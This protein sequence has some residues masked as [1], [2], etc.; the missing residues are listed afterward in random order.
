MSFTTLASLLA[1]AL[2]QGMQ[3]NA[4]LLG[5][6]DGGDPGNAFEQRQQQALRPGEHPEMPSPRTK[7]QFEVIL[8]F[9]HETGK[10]RSIPELMDPVYMFSGEFYENVVDMKIRGRGLDFVWGRKYGSKTIGTTPMGNGWD[11]SYNIYLTPQ[12]PDFLVNNGWGRQDLYQYDATTG[13]W[14]RPQVF[15][16]LVLN[17]DGTFTLRFQDTSSW[18][19]MG[20]TGTAADGKLSMTADRNANSM[21]FAYDAQGRLG[22]VTDTLKRKI[23]IQYNSSG[24]VSTVT[25]FDGRSLKYTYHTG[26]PGGGNP[27][28]L[29]SATSP[30]VTGTPTGNDFPSGKTVRYTYSMGNPQAAL[31]GNLLTVTDARGQTYLQNEYYATTNPGALEFDR[32]RRQH[33]GN[34]TDV[35]DVVYE[36]LLAAP[37]NNNATIKAIVN[38]RMGHVKEL[39]YDA[40]HDPVMFQE[41]TGVSNP[42]LPTS[43]TANR[44]GP[45]LRPSDPALFTTIWMYNADSLVTRVVFPNKNEERFVYDSSN[46]DPRARGNLLEHQHL[47]GAL[48]GDQSLIVEKFTYVNGFGGGCCGAN[49]VA[50]EMDGRGNLTRHI[51][52]TRGNRV[53]TDYAEPGTVEEWEY[54]SN[55]QM[56]ARMH[57]DNGS[58]SRRRDEYSYH[59]S[60]PETGYPASQT[61]DVNNLALKTQFRTDG[62]GNVVS[63]LDPRGNTE[64][65]V[66][67]QLD[68]EIQRFERPVQTPS[69]AVS[70]ETQ[71]LFD[72]N[73]NRVLELRLNVDGDGAVDPNAYLGTSIDYDIL[74]QP[75]RIT[76]EVDATHNAVTEMTYNSNWKKSK[77]SF[78]QAVSGA[79]PFNAVDF[80][81]DERDLLY[82]SVLAKGGPDQS[83]VQYD[84]DGN[85]NLALR[86]EGLEGTTHSKA[87]SHDGF[88]R[89]VSETDAMGNRKV[90][91]HD[92]NG[93]T[94]SVR[95][96]GEQQDIAGSANNIRLRER[97]LYYDRLN[98]NVREEEELFDPLTQAPILVGATPD[99]VVV[100]EWTLAPA[101]MPLVR[102]NDNQ[103][104]TTYKYDTVNRISSVTD[105]VG[106]EVRKF[107]DLNSNLVNEETTELSSVM[108]NPD[109]FFSDHYEYDALNRQT[110]RIDNVGNRSETRYDSRGNQ[111]VMTDPVGNVTRRAYDG[112]NRM[113]QTELIMTSDGTGAGAPAGSI[114]NTTTWDDSSRVIGKADD[115]GNSTAFSYDSLNR[116]TGE[117]LADGTQAAFSYDV[118]DN[119]VSRLDANGTS[120]V[121]SYDLLNRRVQLNVSVGAGVS[122]DTTFVTYQYDGRS[123][124]M[125]C[126]DDDSLVERS[127]DSMDNLL[128]ETLNGQTTGHVFDGLNNNLLLNYPSGR[129]VASTYDLLERKTK[130]TDGTGLVAQM[131][132]LGFG[133]LGRIDFG[134][135]T[136]ANFTFDGHS[137]S[138]SGVKR[139]VAV[140]HRLLSNGAIFHSQ[141]FKWDGAGNKLER[142]DSRIG[143]FGITHSY[144]Y[145]SAYRLTRGAS[146]DSSGVLR[147]ETYDLDGRGNRGTTSGGST[148]GTY[149][150]DGTVPSPADLQ[151]NQYT[152]TAFDER[153][154]DLNGN[155]LRTS[156]SGCLA[157]WNGDYIIDASDLN[158]YYADWTAQTPGADVN[159]D[160]IVDVAD[161]VVFYN[162]WLAGCSVNRQMQYDYA[163]RLVAFTDSS[164]RVTNYR[165]DGFGRR[166][167]RIVDATGLFGS[168]TET[169]YFY[170]GWQVLE[171]QSAQDAMLASYVYG[172]FV[173]HV[174]Q[175][176]RAGRPYYYHTDDMFN[177]MAMTDSAGAVVERYEYGDYGEVVSPSTLLAIIGNPSSIDNPY[178]FNGRRY[179]SESGFYHYRT[180]YMDPRAGRFLTRDT[181][182]I[183]GD[184]SALGNG[185][186]FA[187]NNPWSKLDPFGL[188]P[189]KC[190]ECC[191]NLK[192]KVAAAFDACNKT[193]E[194]AY[195]VCMTGV[196]PWV[197][198]GAVGGAGGVVIGLLVASNPVGWVV[199]GLAI[200][201]GAVVGGGASGG[202]AA[203]SCSR[204]RD[205]SLEIC[206]RHCD[207]EKAK[208]GEISWYEF[209]YVQGSEP[210]EW[211]VK[212]VTCKCSYKCE[213]TAK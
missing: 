60:G 90:F 108:G 58:G 112:L 143:G 76:E 190:K 209:T 148:P 197:G 98:R 125:T 193:A 20:F 32:I 95:L 56:T 152:A 185:A 174:V 94:T 146:A 134:N 117:T 147:R 77:T 107:Y 6:V 46:P 41:F 126:K 157:D 186:T 64:L 91:G 182:G 15:R 120:V 96:Q 99:G 118:H 59:T 79:D 114:T 67:N 82:R 21:L 100:T 39:Y 1:L 30:A 103:H 62:R 130:I 68:Q 9:S 72:A 169:R 177:V 19:F 201:G 155:T 3:S 111:V 16:E 28:D 163:N 55:G 208:C 205:K 141:E 43:S 181:I 196:A 35:I 4:P 52:D 87:L 124:V 7:S 115:A 131:G 204:A 200:V 162:A 51:Y 31:N 116:L 101:S 83:T 158:A 161:L 183:W 211:K 89:V 207:E 170:S 53:H 175:M 8:P 93:N 195:E 66:Y 113:L 202:A 40:L 206:K 49:F 203:L 26:L 164:G 38:D 127:Y 42:S 74:N 149:V 105:A 109:E 47:A 173:D 171:E 45:A 22:V 140:N 88:D 104:K 154:Y 12:G 191:D 198:G 73:N 165:H 70:Y 166:T 213:Y 54:N 135:G 212:K 168:P 129:R 85:G 97:R 81:Y 180:R 188:D 167:A 44:P 84:Y 34:A 184:R 37:S 121:S 14:I 187:S 106:N 144:E 11:H 27:G 63:I 178:L 78:G 48:G 142:K 139:I 61:L 10:Q 189:I 128:Q 25:D 5:T 192:T 119:E 136:Q 18:N 50:S 71:S 23:R 179:D 110:A 176:N 24:F 86:I 29:A 2:T 151:L 57:A 17:S 122:A 153:V 172:T 92:A 65:H 69:G 159:G 80:I 145:D 150:L 194:E 13:T 102:V 210:A 36:A 138:D 123:L 132:Y 156:D 33:W 137:A 75:I 133:R 160:G 199:C